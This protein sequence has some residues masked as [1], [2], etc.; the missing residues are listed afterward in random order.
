M[1]CNIIC[2]R[3]WIMLSLIRIQLM[4]L[5]GMVD[6]MPI[7]AHGDADGRTPDS[8]TEPASNQQY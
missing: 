8:R 7:N 6:V 4:V 2:F 5:N 3:S 1:V